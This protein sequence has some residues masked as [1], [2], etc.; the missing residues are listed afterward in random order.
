MTRLICGRP[1]TPPGPVDLDRVLEP[2]VVRHR[3]TG[4][5]I[6]WQP[7]G[8]TALGRADDVAEIVS[9]L[10]ANAQRHAANS[11]V[12]LAVRTTPGSIE[13]VVSD[14]GPGVDH[15]LRRAIFDW[16][17]RSAS[18]PGQ[19]VGLASARLLSMEL[20]GYLKLDDRA[21]PGA[22]FVL[23]LPMAEEALRDRART[24]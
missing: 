19:G 2:I 1:T 17:R 10:L 9:I 5:R 22:T 14:A 16:G 8:T 3:A 24:A 20:G 18:S 21:G 23:G 4:G 11:S 13:I 12:G 15:Q 7:T 6:D